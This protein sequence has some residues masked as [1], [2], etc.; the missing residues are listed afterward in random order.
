M[1]CMLPIPPLLTKYLAAF[2]L[3]AARESRSRFR[4]STIII[5]GMHIHASVTCEYA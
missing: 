4:F 2:L 3:E 1:L 5:P